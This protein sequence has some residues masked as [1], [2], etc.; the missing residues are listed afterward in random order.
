[1]A[2]PFNPFARRGQRAG[3]TGASGR[4]RGSALNARSASFQPK[5]PNTPQQS[6]PR[7]LGRGARSARGRGAAVSGSNTSTSHTVAGPSMSGSINSPF[8]QLNQKK[9]FSSV[10]GGQASQQKPGFLGPTNGVAT[11]NYTNGASKSF[12]ANT[13]G[14]GIGGSVPVEDASVLNHYHER[15]EQVSKPSLANSA[16]VRD[17]RSHK[18]Y[19]SK[20]TGRN[21][22]R[23]PSKVDRWRTPTSPPR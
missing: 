4:G 8:A 14:E 22:D 16:A 10:F 9:S 12:Q 21:D 1:M 5:N 17:R 2:T 6:K 13:M 23:R 11:S 15:Y 19:S 20:S 7:G 3:A 18:Y